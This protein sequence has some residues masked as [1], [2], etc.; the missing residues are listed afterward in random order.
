VK[1]GAA[2][3]VAILAVSLA[4]WAGFYAMTPDTPLTGGETLVVVGV[5]AA[6]VIGVRLVWSRLRGS[7]G[8]DARQV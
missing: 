3:L 8:T 5:C 4:V 6:L 2:T 1:A 7:R